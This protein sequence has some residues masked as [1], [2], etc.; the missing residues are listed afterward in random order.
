M[1]LLIVNHELRFGLRLSTLATLQVAFVTM[2]SHMFVEIAFLG[3]RQLTSK[4][5]AL[6]GFFLVVRAKVVE[7]IVPLLEGLFA[8][9]EVTDEDLGPPFALQVQVGDKL[10]C[11]KR[12]ETESAFKGGKVH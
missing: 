12:R 10:E 6:E 5:R 8:T 1:T 11:S 9:L 7:D 4:D 2:D 3:E